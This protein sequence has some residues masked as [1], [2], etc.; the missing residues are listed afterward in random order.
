MAETT[1]AP[2]PHA[3]FRSRPAAAGCDES[4]VM[5]PWPRQ[6]TLVGDRATAPCPQRTRA[7]RTAAAREALKSGAPG[8]APGRPALPSSQT[9]RRRRLRPPVCRAM[10]RRAAD[11]RARADRAAAALGWLTRESPAVRVGGGGG[12]RRRVP[13]PSRPGSLV[14]AVPGA[15]RCLA[16]RRELECRSHGTTHQLAERAL[17]RATC[18]QRGEHVF[19]KVGGRSDGM[20]AADA[21]EMRRFGSAAR[22][23]G[24]ETATGLAGR[25]DRQRTTPSARSRCG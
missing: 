4:R 8:R 13:R 14:R 25:R 3:L 24:T 17:G 15:E 19:G 7:A 11:V 20:G 6:A 10:Y 22:K 5:L 9:G 23:D 16:Q 12:G 2:I 1:K 18:R 21:S